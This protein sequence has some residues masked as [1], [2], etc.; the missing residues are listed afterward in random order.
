MA[1]LDE[2]GL[3]ELWSLVKAK[4]ASITPS[5][6]G[7][8]FNYTR[9]MHGGGSNSCTTNCN[10]LTDGVYIMHHSAGNTP[11]SRSSVVYHK[12]WDFHGGTFS[13]Q[14]GMTDDKRLLVRYKVSSTWGGW[15]E[16]PVGKPTGSYTGNGSTS[17]R[18]IDTGGKGNAIVIWNGA[19]MSFAALGGAIYKDNASSPATMNYDKVQFVEGILTLKTNSSV[20]NGSGTVYQ[21]QV[22]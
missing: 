4:V 10:N 3:A 7:A 11:L 13:T 19:T 17:S 22:L 18:T 8:Y 20:L 2:T 5:G 15:L 16:V 12:D 6:I 21:Y 14:I 9:E 1:F